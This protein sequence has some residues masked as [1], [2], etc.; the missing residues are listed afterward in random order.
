MQRCTISCEAREKRHVK[1]W[2][3]MT[4]LEWIP[5]W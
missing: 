4:I 3:I 5:V 2:H 1:S